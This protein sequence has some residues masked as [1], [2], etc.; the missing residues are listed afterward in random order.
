MIL[1]YEVW[2]GSVHTLKKNTETL[3]VASKKNGLEI[4]V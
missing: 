4:N 1:I 2:G 3:T